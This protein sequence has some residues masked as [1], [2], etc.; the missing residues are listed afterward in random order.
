[1][2]NSRAVQGCAWRFI[3]KPSRS[4]QTSPKRVRRSLTTRPNYFYENDRQ[5][6]RVRYEF[7]AKRVGTFVHHSVPTRSHPGSVRTLN[8]RLHQRRPTT[9]R[10]E[11]T[12]WI[13][14]WTIFTPLLKYIDAGGMKP[15]S[16]PYGSVGPYEANALRE[17]VGHQ[18][19][20]I[21]RDIT[22]EKHGLGSQEY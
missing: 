5:R 18:T 22:W 10:P 21:G 17:R 19:N 3:R 16:Y 13:A 4:R 7:S 11:E 14:A 1:M 8:F 20:V 2:R 12:N 15:Y 6:T 9:F